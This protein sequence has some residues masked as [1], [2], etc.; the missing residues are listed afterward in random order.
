MEKVA[1]IL[2]QGFADWEYGLIAGTGGPFYG[3]DTGFFTPN[4]GEIRSMGGLK[5]FI[6]DGVE[7]IRDWSPKVIVVI[8]GTIWETDDAPVLDDLLLAHHSRGGVVAGICGGTLAL[9]R[10]GL[11]DD[12]RHTSNDADYLHRHAPGYAGSELF[13]PVPE[14]VVDN[15]VITAPG[16][17]PAAFAAAVFESAGLDHDA[18]LAFR[19]ML[20]AEHGA[21]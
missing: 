18:A 19:K 21:E 10:A 3:L 5:A 15:R 14:A 9:A 20:G 2:T 16:T 6:P 1:L 4:T 13:V 7:A 11:L 12:V 17:A 8:G